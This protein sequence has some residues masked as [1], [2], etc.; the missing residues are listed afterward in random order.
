MLD[1][2]GFGEVARFRLRFEWRSG[3]TVQVVE[4]ELPERQ[5]ILSFIPSGVAGPRLD[6][7]IDDV[8]RWL[9]VGMVAAGAEQLPTQ[10]DEGPSYR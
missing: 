2:F 6:L 1:G 9:Q 3:S 4:V 7:A 8:Q 5:L 10:T